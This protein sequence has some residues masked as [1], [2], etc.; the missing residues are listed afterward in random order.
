MTMKSITTLAAALFATQV[1][2]IEIYYDLGE[3]HP[4][5]SAERITAEDFAGVQP[6]VGDSV[7]RY[8]GWAEGNP[9]LFQV[10]RSGPTDSGNDPDIYMNLHENPD[11]HF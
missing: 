4:D 1:S 3:G 6:S 8:H 10:D 5:L 7:D 9:D 2:A 11:L